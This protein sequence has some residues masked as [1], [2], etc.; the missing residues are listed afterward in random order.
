[1]RYVRAVLLAGL[2]CAA[3]AGGAATASASGPFP[4][5][6]NTPGTVMTANN[7]TI[8]I[9][10]PAGQ[11]VA[12]CNQIRVQAAINAGGVV[13]LP[14]GSVTFIGCMAGG[15]GIVVNQ[16][17]AWTGIF[18]HLDIVTPWT[19]PAFTLDLTIPMGGIRVT[20]A[21]CAF[22]LGGNPLGDYVFRVPVAHNLLVDI[23]SITFPASLDRTPLRLTTGNVG[24]GCGLL[25][26]ANGQLAQLNGVFAANP[27]INGM[28]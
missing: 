13:T 27:V 18:R 20:A 24:A 3:L 9:N 7:A 6:I 21:G 11:L 4:D 5:I 12:T 8:R 22:D 17:I 16:P 10:R 23:P 2:V 1:M 26:I 28:G 14:A 15:V 19:I 25:G